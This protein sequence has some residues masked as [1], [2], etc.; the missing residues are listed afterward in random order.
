MHDAPAGRFKRCNPEL[1][2]G[3]GINRRPKQNNRRNVSYFTLLKPNLELQPRNRP[4]RPCAIFQKIAMA[5]AQVPRVAFDM[6]LF[7]D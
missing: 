6:R 7:W 3:E 5:R 1:C 4:L 2:L